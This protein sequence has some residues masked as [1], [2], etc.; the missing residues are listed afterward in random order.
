MFLTKTLTRFMINSKEDK[1][2]CEF[3]FGPEF[4]QNDELSN[5]KGRKMFK[6]LDDKVTFK[7]NQWWHTSLK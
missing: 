4:C 5:S 1:I 2:D 6:P 7:D 3:Q